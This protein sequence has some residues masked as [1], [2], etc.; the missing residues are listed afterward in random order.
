MPDIRVSIHTNTD[1]KTVIVDSS[2]TPKQVLEAEGVDYS[3]AMTHLDGSAL[4][5]EG[6]NKSFDAFGITDKAILAVVIKSVNR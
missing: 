3:T 5:T 6:M 1:R 2:M 4:P